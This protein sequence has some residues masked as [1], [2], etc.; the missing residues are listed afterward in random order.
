MKSG[1]MPLM[2]AYRHAYRKS[3]QQYEHR[4]HTQDTPICT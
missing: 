2:C 3:I 1:N 4:I